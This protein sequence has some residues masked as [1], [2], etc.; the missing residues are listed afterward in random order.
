MT[1]PVLTLVLPV[2]QV[3]RFLPACLDSLIALDPPA[4]EIIAVDDGSTDACPQILASYADRLPGLRIIRQANAGVSAARNTGLAVARGRYLA[5]VDPDDY[6]AADAYRQALAVAEREDLEIVL[7]NGEYDCEGR[8]PPAPIYR[9]PS[10][11]ITSGAE[12]LRRRLQ[13]RDLLHMAWLHLYR[14]DFLRTHGFRFIPGRLHED[15]LW[16]TE[17]LLAAR[18]VR[19]LDHLAV[20]YRR[21]PRRRT[22][23]QQQA[24]L[25][26][27]VASSIA[28]ARGL[29]E[30]I[31]EQPLDE[32]L[33]ALLGWQ[34]VDGAFAIFHKLEQMPDQRRAWRWRARLAREHFFALLWRHAYDTRQRRRILRHAMKSTLAR[35][36]AR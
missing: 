2:Y 32:E 8:E 20:Y 13:A 7:F 23:E 9:V 29:A 26:A 34:L 19:Y 28:N 31:A 17:V 35:L 18:R 36:I 15:V 12:W 21:W 30:L 5:F 33:R 16:T 11:P 27:L 25:E 10:G 6:L 4:D 1:E 14:H 24:H 3:E 22:A